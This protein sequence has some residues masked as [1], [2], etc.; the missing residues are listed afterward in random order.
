[1]SVDNAKSCGRS[2]KVISWLLNSAAKLISSIASLQNTNS[3]DFFLL[4]FR[5]VSF[6]KWVL[7]VY[8]KINIFYLLIR[9]RTCAHQG[10]RNINF[11]EN[12]AYLLTHFMPVVSFYTPW[13]HQET[14]DFLIF[15]GEIERDQWHESI[16]ESAWKNKSLMAFW[17]I[18]YLYHHL[19]R[20]KKSGKH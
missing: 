4:S 15:S 19:T 20:L 3:Y 13:K 17:M 16:F 1:M 9:T 11:S 7:K 8:Q 10:L 12:F 18:L 2:I 6:I 5:R 14:W